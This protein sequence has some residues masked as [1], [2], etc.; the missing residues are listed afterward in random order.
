MRKKDLRNAV[1]VAADLGFA[2]KA[3]SFATELDLP[4][5]FVEKRRIDAQVEVLTVIGEVADR[6]VILVDD[7]VDTAGTMCDD[8]QAL[9]RAGAR[10]IY[11][12]FVHPVLSGD[13]A[14]LLKQQPICEIV[15]TNSVPLPPHK[16]LPNMTVISVAPLLAGVIR[17]VHE[18][19]SVGEMFVPYHGYS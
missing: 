13:A 9:K 12:C 16:L 14:E 5:A 4:V 19:S 2:K 1:V 10:D 15:T 8:I 18:G 7:E 3:R 17:R 11:C 6:D